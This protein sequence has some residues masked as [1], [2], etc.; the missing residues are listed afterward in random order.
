MCITAARSEGVRNRWLPR[1]GRKM[2]DANGEWKRHV[3]VKRDLQSLPDISRYWVFIVFG[4]SI[5]VE[6][7]RGDRM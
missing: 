5:E 4:V 7:T 1:L 3:R 6:E 2:I